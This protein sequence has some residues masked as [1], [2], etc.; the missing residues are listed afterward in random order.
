MIRPTM[1]MAWTWGVMLLALSAAPA[2][3]EGGSVA[4]IDDAP[5]PWLRACLSNAERRKEGPW[6]GDA[7]TWHA[8]YPMDGFID[9]YLASRDTAW[10]DAA[11]A[12]YDWCIDQLLVGPDGQKG[13]L[14]A[15]YRMPGRL[16]EYPVGDALMIG[17][18]VRF[19]ELVLKDEP[20]L[21]AA[22]GAAG[23]RY[24]ELA[25]ALV[26]RKWDRRG[27]WHEDGPC[28][29][30]T[31]WAWTF[32]QDAPDR[33]APPPEGTPVTTLPIN[34]QVHWGVIAA[35]LWRITG[36]TAW[37]QR[38]EKIFNFAKSRLN[39]YDDHY[40]WNYWEPFGPWDIKAGNDQDFNSW[41]NTHPYRNYQTG[42]VGAFVE[43]YHRG[44]TFDDA[45]MR[46]LLRTNLHVMWNGKLDAPA[47]HNSDA[48]VQQ[49]ALGEIRPGLADPA[50]G[51]HAGGL[52]GALVPF[53]ASARKL[54][55]AHLQAGTIDYA[56]Y[57][58]VIAPTPPRL[59]PRYA[60]DRPATLEVPFHPCS[61]ITM[62]AV[63]PGAIRRGE[64]AVAACQGRLPG[65]L[66]VELRSADGLQRLAVLAEADLRLIVNV[67]WDTADVEPGRYRIRWTL[68]DEY[69]EFPIEI[70]R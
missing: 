56:Y 39:L 2:A 44:I 45:D 25:E 68:K 69:R 59:A 28:G 50:T 57:H 24:V 13:W 10:L 18:M 36:E 30:Y 42:E 23:R 1:K 46:R 66:T 20:A 62:A 41:I 21:A 7:W 49:A 29:A 6:T 58:N 8:R 5:Q 53:D 31:T 16:G 11:A 9:A 47:W 22:Y 14:G 63:I 43:A 48:G 4:A 32:T 15:A 55:E 64:P 37:R 51:R 35:R 40:S 3:G 26:F 33:W 60:E 38:A 17:P 34:M 70:R 19:S 67:P 52:W 54:H 27:I 12:Y 65:R 61:T